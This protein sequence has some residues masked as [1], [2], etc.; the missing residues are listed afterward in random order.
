MAAKKK[1]PST[2]AKG[3]RFEDALG[4]LETLVRALESG[5][6]SLDESLEHFE[7]GVALS[8]YCRH[9]LGE[10]EQKVRVLLEQ[11]GEESLQTF[12]PGGSPIGASDGTTGG[13]TG[14][15]TLT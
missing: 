5:D 14:G 7:R 9:S 15:E 3:T 6:G 2:V 12:E 4:E 13:T 8:R 1:T 10:A 11:D